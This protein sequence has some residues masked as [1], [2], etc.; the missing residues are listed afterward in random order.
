MNELAE[1]VPVGG[2]GL[3]VIPFGQWCRACATEREARRLHSW[4]QLQH[5]HQGTPHPCGSR[6]H[7]LFR[8]LFWAID[9]CGEAVGME[10]VCGDGLQFISRD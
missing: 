2:D 6:S 7:L 1:R 4:H 8:R 3:T 10:D 5:P 9:Q